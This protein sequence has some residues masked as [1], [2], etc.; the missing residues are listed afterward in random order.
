MMAVVCNSCDPL[1][2]PQC[3]LCLAECE[4]SFSHQVCLATVALVFLCQVT[5]PSFCLALCVVHSFLLLCFVGCV[6]CFLLSLLSSCTK[7]LPVLHVSLLWHFFL[8]FLGFVIRPVKINGYRQ[9]ASMVTYVLQLD[10]KG[11]LP[12]FVANKITQYQPL[13]WGGEKGREKRGGE[14]RK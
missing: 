4:G 12:P 2:T 1:V 14:R 11:W 10:C 5:S 7:G 6:V 9:H 13:R 3:H 8:A